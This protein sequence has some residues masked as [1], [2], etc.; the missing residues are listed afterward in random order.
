MQ[1]TKFRYGNDVGD[2]LIAIENAIAAI[3]DAQEEMRGLGETEDEFRALCDVVDALT[4]KK[5]KY[6]SYMS[7]EYQAQFAEM[8]REYWRSVI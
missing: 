4:A 5:D 7:G 3:E 1:N 2:V 6:E 8:A